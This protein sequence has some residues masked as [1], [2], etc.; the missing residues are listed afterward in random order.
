VLMALADGGMQFLI[1]GARANMGIVAG[2][3]FFEVKVVEALM[4][5][6]GSAAGRQRIPIPRQLVR[7]GFSAKGSSLILGD[8]EDGVCFDSEGFYWSE[9]KRTAAASRFGRDQVIGVLLNLDPKSPNCNTLSVFCN[10]ERISPPQSLPERLKGKALFP[11]VAYRNVSVQVNFGPQPLAML[12]FQ[13]RMLQGAAKADMQELPLA[14]VKDGKYT[15]L[16]PVAFPDEGT[17]DWL[18]DFLEKNPQYTELSDR[19]IQEWAISSGIWK[20]K[21]NSWKNSNDKPDFNFGIQYMDDFSVQRVINAISP[22]MPRHYVVMEVK[23]NL[24]ADERK[25]NLQRFNLPHF[26]KVAHVIMGDPSK[27]FQAKVHKKMLDDKQEEEDRKWKLK[28]LEMERKRAIKERQAA[29]EK[30]RKQEELNR[31]AEEEEKAKVEAEAKPAEDKKE[32]ADA[33]A[34]PEGEVKDDTEGEN[35]GVEPAKEADEP[36]KDASEESKKEEKK[37]EDE[38]MMDETPPK[39]ELTEVEKQAKFRVLTVPD[40]SSF[41]MSSGFGHFCIPEKTEG[42]DDIIYEWANEDGSRDYLSKWVLQ[43]KITSRMDDLQPSE[44]F[45]TKAAE[46]QKALQEW[47]TKQ[48]EHQN[49]KKAEEKKKPG[50]EGA[51]DDDET[52]R[53][54]VDIFSVEDVCNVGNGVPL[55]VDFSFEDW[56][57][58]S[59]RFELYLLQAAFKHDVDDPERVGIHESHILFYYH[60]YYRKQLMPRLYGKDSI[61]DVCELIKDTVKINS[62]D[63]VLVSQLSTEPDAPD[64]FV[65]LQ[66]ES[67]RK[68]QQRIDAGDETAR[69]DFSVLHQQQQQPV[70]GGGGKS[71]SKGRGGRG[72]SQQ[73]YAPRFGM[74]MRN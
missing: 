42:F 74:G 47:Q 58:L 30:A 62:D 43:K 49:A 66:E 35:K 51:D 27:D 31:K 11:H 22:F 33:K 36:K 12:P 15:V 40:I 19:K 44:W 41:V 55:F 70:G 61:E 69:L 28:K 56:A 9:K 17:F 72:W 18:D 68:R 21:T 39:A 65:K 53:S 34:N 32:G 20:P 46:Y 14:K 73:T 59:L 24:V 37:E 29:V 6:D 71:G 54:D 8:S 5:S 45:K 2:R 57:L 52:K 26:K 48:K 16:Y 64:Q 25:A 23:Q 38:E 10:G 13:C 4:P 67:R 1:A 3:Y 60:R 50:D 63:K 7:L